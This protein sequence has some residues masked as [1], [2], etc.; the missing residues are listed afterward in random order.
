V[1][2]NVGTTP[3]PNGIG[4]VIETDTDYQMEQEDE[5]IL[6]V[7]NGATIALPLEPLLAF[8]VWIEADGGPVTVTG[9]IQGGNVILPQGTIGVFTYSTISGTWSSVVGTGVSGLVATYYADNGSTDIVVGDV[10]DTTLVTIT[11]IAA[12]A[13]Q[14]LL[15]HATVNYTS[16]AGNGVIFTGV[17]VSQ[18]PGPFVIEDATE[19]STVIMPSHTVTRVFQVTVSTSGTYS[20]QLQGI[21][22][23][24]AT[25]ATVVGRPP[26]TGLT[27]SARLTVEVIN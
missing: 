26:G 11:G 1:A 19:D 20:V 10:S 24:G 21:C 23:D 7:Q 22:Q 5:R 13:G 14:K 15:I 6:V 18:P 4:N 27:P 17:Y 3:G 25:S 12:I 9:P 8:P 16:I 2:T